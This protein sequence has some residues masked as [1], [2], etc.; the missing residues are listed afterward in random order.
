MGLY[1]QLEEKYYELMERLHL[2]DAFVRPIEE[3]GIPSFPVAVLLVLLI[4]AALA[5][6]LWFLFAGGAP[7]AQ[8]EFKITVL[9]TDGTLLDGAL[10][11]VYDGSDKLDS[12]STAKGIV[13]FD[14][15]P[16]KTLTLRVNK[17]GYELFE[18]DFDFTENKEFTVELVPAAQPTEEPTGGEEYANPTPYEPEDTFDAS[19]DIYVKNYDSQLGIDSIVRV[20]DAAN[21]VQIGDDLVAENGRTTME[22]L[23]KGQRV[24]VMV[25]ADGFIAYDGHSVKYLLKAGSV[26]QI[27]VKLRRVVTNSTNQSE[28]NGALTAINVR[29]QSGAGIAKAN[30]GVFKQ[31]QTAILTSKLTDANGSAAFNLSLVN[32]SVEYE[33]YYATAN[34]TGYFAQWSGYFR[35]GDN[36]TIVLV[37]VSND[38]TA[39]LLVAVKDERDGKGVTG[40][41]Y[42]VYGS[43]AGQDVLLCRGTTN[44][45]GTGLCKGLQRETS[46][47]VRASKGARSA[48][49]EVVALTGEENDVDLTLLLPRAKIICTAYDAVTNDSVGAAQFTA[50]YGGASFGSCAGVGC[51]I[52]VPATVQLNVTVTATDYAYV[53]I[54]V[55]VAANDNKTVD[56]K[57]FPLS[58]VKESKIVLQK[59]IDSDTGLEVTS[60][61]LGHSYE[62]VFTLAGHGGEA[63]GAF[64]SLGDASVGAI[65]GHVQLGMEN[66]G[67]TTAGCNPEEVD[68]S[69]ANGARKKYAWL[70][71]SYYSGDAGANGIFTKTILLHVTVNENAQLDPKTKRAAMPLYYRSYVKRGNAIFRNPYDETL[72]AD[73]DSPLESGCFAATIA[74]SYDVYSPS[75]TCQRGACVTLEFSQDGRSGPNEGFNASSFLNMLDGADVQPMVVRYKIEV[76]NDLGTSSVF[77]VKW[78]DSNAAELVKVSTPLQMEDPS[79]PGTWICGGSTDYYFPTEDD[80][81]RASEFAAYEDDSGFV[82]NLNKLLKCSNYAPPSKMNKTFSASGVIYLKPL[83]A[84]NRVDIAARFASG[85]RKPPFWAMVTPP[86]AS[87]ASST[88]S[89]LSFANAGDFSNPWVRFVDAA[90]AESFFSEADGSPTAASVF[91]K[92]F[93]WFRVNSNAT[94]AS[95]YAIVELQFEQTANKSAGGISGKKDS[96]KGIFEAQSIKDCLVCPNNLTSCDEDVKIISKNCPYGPVRIHFRITVRRNRNDQSFYLM[97]TPDFLKLKQGGAYYY[98]GKDKTPKIVTEWFNEGFAVDM[99]TLAKG[100]VIEG[101]AMAYSLKQGH[102]PVELGHRMNDVRDDNAPFDTSVER[103]V[104]VSTKPPAPTTNIIRYTPNDNCFGKV[105]V[106]FDATR[107]NDNVFIN[108]GCSNV[109]MRIST[110]LPGDG[111]ITNVSTGSAAMLARVVSGD[112]D[113]AACYES[114]DYSVDKNG[115]A[116]IGKCENGFTK[117]LTAKGTHLLRYNAVGANCPA[118][119]KVVANSVN[120][121]SMLVEIGAAGSASTVKLNLTVWGVEN[122]PCTFFPTENKCKPAAICELTQ[123]GSA[124]QPNQACTWKQAYVKDKVHLGHYTHFT[125]IKSLYIAPVMSWFET[126]CTMFEEINGVST[127]ICLEYSFKETFPQLWAVVN[128]QQYGNRSIY[129]L[130]RGDESDI[131]VMKSEGLV[132][133]V[134]PI[135]FD[136][137]GTQ[138]FAFTPRTGRKMVAYE[139]RN[140]VAYTGNPP[141]T[142][143]SKTPLNRLDLT[144]SE[145]AEALTGQGVFEAVDEDALATK[146]EIDEATGALLSQESKGFN[147]LKKNSIYMRNVTEALI[148]GAQRTANSLAYWRSFSNTMYCCCN[149]GDSNSQCA[150]DVDCDSLTPEDL[151]NPLL[152]KPALEDWRNMTSNYSFKD[153]GCVFCNNTAPFE[154]KDCSLPQANQN[155]LGHLACTDNPNIASFD[156]DERCVKTIDDEDVQVGM[157][158]IDF[159]EEF[160]GKTCGVPASLVSTDTITPTQVTECK[161]AMQCALMLDEVDT[162][163]CFI[164]QDG[165]GKLSQEDFDADPSLNVHPA[166]YSDENAVFECESEEGDEIIAVNDYCNAQCDNWCSDNDA[167]SIGCDAQTGTFQTLESEAPTQDGWVYPANT[168]IENPPIHAITANQT[169]S[170]RLWHLP[171][172]FFS[173]YRAP[174]FGY[175]F[176]FAAFNKTD[177]FQSISTIRSVKG[178]TDQPDYKEQGVYDLKVHNDLEWFANTGQEQFFGEANSVRLGKDYYLGARCDKPRDKW[179]SVELCAPLWTDYSGWNSHWKYGACVNTLYQFDEQEGIDLFDAGKHPFLGKVGSMVSTEGMPSVVSP[180][181]FLLAYSKQGITGGGLG[182]KYSWQQIAFWTPDGSFGALKQFKWNIS[183]YRRARVWLGV[184]SGA[185]LGFALCSVPCAVAGAVIGGFVG[186]QSYYNDVANGF[187]VAL[188]I[189]ASITTVHILL[190]LLPG[191]IPGMAAGLAPHALGW[192]GFGVMPAY[193]SSWFGYIGLSAAGGV[194]AGLLSAHVPAPPGFVCQ[195]SQGF[196]PKHSD[197]IFGACSFGYSKGSRDAPWWFSTDINIESKNEDKCVPGGL[198]DQ[199]DADVL[200]RNPSC[201][202]ED[203]APGASS[204]MASRRSGS[205]GGSAGDALDAVKQGTGT[206]KD[207]A[208]TV[209]SVSEVF[210]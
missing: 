182:S 162:P 190:I 98:V 173:D 185:V 32:A 144:T 189:G 40:A 59:V 21:N 170:Q 38:T 24:Y 160:K 125:P 204:G 197:I 37:Q 10:V 196:I 157:A 155:L 8:G 110:I 192:Y 70:D 163:Y 104:F 16:R 23:E 209:K 208:S 134:P 7:Q 177:S 151:A 19:L 101:V 126:N 48:S 6:G 57:L 131:T 93:T 1:E 43:F 9:S 118:R 39:S 88:L 122:Q 77:A 22:G 64:F 78:S 5:A 100:T 183:W 187:Y 105:S 25:E 139:N 147:Y 103:S 85:S 96:G 207:A 156:C 200:F 42:G 58:T 106:G 99:G 184:A 81:P 27:T 186:Y 174:E 44:S 80:T 178:C 14:A 26:N 36:V 195:N 165:D 159:D 176:V 148:G 135:K 150:I 87:E 201:R 89:S 62:F 75:T 13:Y 128:H 154:G 92:H 164:D 15:L 115:E 191:T 168:S 114:C 12:G 127:G 108:E 153:H 138:V 76:F 95:D 198:I 74:T 129:I 60:L 20:Y 30:V 112:A 203:A 56:V 29:E 102:S 53:E 34:K 61:R 86:I 50:F 73:V 107:T 66:F 136:G 145:Y 205:S 179:G 65:T 49:E 194:G 67:A 71:V 94:S 116:K 181:G 175:N 130:E 120:G 142:L 132:D 41:S 141:Q 158:S 172:G 90:Q 63:T 166:T 68:Y 202:D 18:D 111:V 31:S 119:Y 171:F 54:P 113:A 152:C 11:Q 109:E 83:A 143:Q 35:A 133:I 117:A 55:T 199:M 161:T 47:T 51:E 79:N 121:S 2:V 46:V 206:V 210:G 193:L 82:L 4:I 169:E 28:I 72:Q 124:T 146:A 45:N 69:N 84:S 3:R 140:V 52:I 188:L 149:N 137:P 17:D 180:M 97:T 33:T 91:A 167:C 123:A